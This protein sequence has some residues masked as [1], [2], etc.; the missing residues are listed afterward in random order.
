[1]DEICDNCGCRRGDYYGE[2]EDSCYGDKNELFESCKSK[3]FAKSKDGEEWERTDNQHS[4]KFLRKKKSFLNMLW[5]ILN[6]FYLEVFDG[7]IPIRRKTHK[8]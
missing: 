7:F 3:K 1:M 6:P 8:N 5:N 2:P 4:E